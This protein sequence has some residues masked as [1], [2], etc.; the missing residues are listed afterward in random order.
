MLA[1]RWWS[2]YISFFHA[3]RNAISSSIYVLGWQECLTYS[4]QLVDNFDNEG[5]DD[6]DPFADPDDLELVRN[7]KKENALGPLDFDYTERDV[8][9]YNLGIGATEKELHWTY[10]GH[11]QF[12]VIPTFGVITAFAA[13]SGLTLDWLPNFNPVY[14][15]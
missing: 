13:S 3:R 14:E 8:I 12:S 6:E 5:S 2:Y 15:K 4:P 11:G 1:I 9:L 7:A 10:E